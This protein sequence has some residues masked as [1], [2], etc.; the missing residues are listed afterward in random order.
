MDNSEAIVELRAAAE[1]ECNNG[2]EILCA[3]PLS[4]DGI[5]TTILPSEL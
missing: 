4:S 1:Q 3:V 2:I 5:L